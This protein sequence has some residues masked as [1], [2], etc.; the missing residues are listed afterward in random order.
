V[1]KRLHTAT[2]ATA[3]LVL[4]WAAA[5]WL[6]HDGVAP[7]TATPVFTDWQFNPFA[8]GAPLDAVQHNT[9]AAR[10]A[11]AAHARVAKV[12]QSGSLRGSDLDGNWGVWV[13]GQLQ[14]SVTLRQRFDYLL[15]ALGEVAHGDLR[16]WIEQQVT[17]DL[18]AAA[19]RQVLAVWDRYITLQQTSFRHQVNG[20]DTST[21]QPALAERSSV[22]RQILG[23]DW[24]QAFYADEERALVAFTEQM[25]AQRAGA[26]V[27]PDAQTALLMSSSS[28]GLNTEQAAQLQ[29]RRAEQ[30]GADAA[31]RLRAEDAQW[32]DW[33]RR[34]NAA[35]QRLEALNA[36][37]ELS[38]LQRGQVQ[39]AY[40]A[41]TFAGG[42]LA[43]ARALLMPDH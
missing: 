17:A 7:Q 15:T 4:A 28:D 38:P 24:A 18:S 40:L 37:P 35:R 14:P 11:E 16:H 43:R 41:G 9:D 27:A 13:G 26:V 22:R 2:A 21:W 23:A 30:F 36:A 29:A 5:A 39:A 34:L 12:W 20:S 8:K 25:T 10:A 31:E 42:E 3:L 6:K 19:S 1:N 32:A 33:E